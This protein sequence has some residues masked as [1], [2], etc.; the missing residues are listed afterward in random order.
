MKQFQSALSVFALYVALLYST[1]LPTSTGV[2]AADTAERDKPVILAWGDSLSA[3][4]GIPVEQ[5]WVS[6]LQ[7][8]LKDSHRV[9]NGSISGETTIGGRTRLPD[10][11][12]KHQPDYMLLALGANDGLRGLATEEMQKNLQAMIELAQQS[13]TKVV[14]LGIKIPP[15]Y[16]MR[17]TDR[18]D[19][20][21]TDLSEQYELPLH[22]FFLERVAL[23][24]D[25][26]QDDG[27]HPTAEA[28][29]MILE[30]I[31]TVLEA[32]L[33]PAETQAEAPA[34]NADTNTND[35]EKT[36]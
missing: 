26:M 16:G 20:V 9:V 23:D 18:F 19:K 11:L 24:F 27:L 8:K 13:D 2:F 3:A 4:Y 6:L 25:L 17:Y 33:I 21:Y 14:L 10:A 30:N 35:N 22:P 29:P 12:E 32:V 28:Q 36:Q 31:W 5:G 1:L 34:E 15:N 7:D